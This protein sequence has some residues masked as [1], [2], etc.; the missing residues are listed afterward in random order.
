MANGLYDKSIDT[1]ERSVVSTTKLWSMVIGLV[2]LVG[3]GMLI[4]FMYGSNMRGSGGP[5]SDNT[6][7]RPAEP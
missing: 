1:D 5:A 3:I 7:T 4:V 2:L 6:S